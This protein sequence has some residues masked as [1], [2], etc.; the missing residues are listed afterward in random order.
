MVNY[1]GLFVVM[2]IIYVVRPRSTS[3]II[4]WSLW[5]RELIC[6]AENNIRKG[7]SMVVVRFLNWA[8]L[9]YLRRFGSY[10][11]SS[12]GWQGASCLYPGSWMRREEPTITCHCVMDRVVLVGAIV[13]LPRQWSRI[14]FVSACGLMITSSDVLYGSGVRWEASSCRT[15]HVVR[16]VNLVVDQGLLTIEYHPS[17]CG[18]VASQWIWGLIVGRL[19]LFIPNRI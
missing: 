11:L 10:P 19:R 6:S 2:R 18:Y 9:R 4:N 3:C 5:Y 7:N 16:M 13:A 14:Y 1:L 8:G 15:V 17:V 12:N